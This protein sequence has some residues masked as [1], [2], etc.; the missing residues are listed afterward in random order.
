MKRV[1]KSMLKVI[2]QYK[3]LKTF[4]NQNPRIVS[5]FGDLELEV[6]MATPAEA[7]EEYYN[8]ALYGASYGAAS[9][10]IGILVLSPQIAVGG[11]TAP[12]FAYIYISEKWIWDSEMDM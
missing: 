6:R 5:H 7:T 12:L 4:T 3:S 8:V 2:S 1:L 9:A 10:G 11:L